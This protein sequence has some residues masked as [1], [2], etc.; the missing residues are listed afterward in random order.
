[1]NLNQYYKPKE[2]ATFLKVSTSTLA[3][4]RHIGIGPE[5]SK[6]DTGSIL[7]DRTD[8]VNFVRECKN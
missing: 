2:A 4:W 6:L 3:R 8:L 5:Y 7:Y 1:M